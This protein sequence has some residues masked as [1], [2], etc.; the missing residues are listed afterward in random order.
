MTD[1]TLITTTTK[2]NE[3]GELINPDGSIAED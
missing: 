3:H 1:A 2:F